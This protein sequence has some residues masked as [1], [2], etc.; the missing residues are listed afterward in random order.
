MAECG[1]WTPC[2]CACHIIIEISSKYHCIFTGIIYFGFSY[3]S[4]AITHTQLLWAKSPKFCPYQKGDKV[5]LEGT[6][7]HTSHPTYKL[8]PKRF[9]PFKVTEVLSSVTYWLDL[10][11]SWQLH[12]AF[13]TS[14]LSLY[15]ET[16]EH[17]VGHSTPAPELIEGEPEW[18]VAEVLASQ[19]FE[20]Q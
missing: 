18:E 6:H 16:L 5:W 9:G 12:N 1:N 11:P 19:H 4:T 10:P 20:R 17:G 14:L 7:L 15:H 3:L 13:H 2:V 8:R